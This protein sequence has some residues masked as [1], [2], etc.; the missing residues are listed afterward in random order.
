MISVQDALS[1]LFDLVTPMPTETA[2]L[3]Q[4][5]GRWLATPAIASRDQPPFDASAMDGYAICGAALPGATFEIIG[6]SAAGHGWQGRL[7][8]GQALRIFT[9]APVPEGAERVVM[10][11][12]VTATPARITLSERLDLSGH[13]RAKGQD[14][15]IGDAVSPRRLRPADVALLAAMNIAEVTVTRRPVVAI[16][17]TGDELVMPGESPAPDQIIASNSFA[18][19]AMVEDTGA[20]ARML[21]IARDTEDSLRTIFGQ[22]E[23]ADLIVTVGGASVGDHDLVGKVAA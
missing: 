10:Q 13:I 9:G 3:A 11:E 19:K 22:A 1:R 18:L 21:P 5:N 23:G 8:P 20:V 6:T 12:D 15:R 7:F 16:I 17:A 14:F 4:A 2:H